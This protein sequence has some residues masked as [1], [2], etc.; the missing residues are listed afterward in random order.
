MLNICDM[1]D[2]WAENGWIRN[3]SVTRS[4][5]WVAQFVLEGEVQVVRWCGADVCMADKGNQ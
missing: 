3:Y 2:T 1:I 4:R 5:C